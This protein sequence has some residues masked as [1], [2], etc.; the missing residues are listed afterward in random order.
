MKYL[1]S[2]V[3][4]KESVTYVGLT[5]IDLSESLLKSHDDLL[6]TLGK[7]LLFS[8]DDKMSKMLSE[9]KELYKYLDLDKLNSDSN[10]FDSLNSLGLKKSEIKNSLDFENFINKPCKFMFLYS[11]D[12]NE[13][14]GLENPDYVL[15]QTWNE[16]IQKWDELK[17][18]LVE[19]DINNFLNKL[20]SRTIQLTDNGKN[21]IYTTSNGN[22]WSLEDDNLADDTFKSNLRKEEL[23]KIIDEKQIEFQV[24]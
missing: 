11:R 4:F 16:T 12:K 20:T 7:E 13:N 8:A 1:K 23:Q 14:A 6:N 3:R 2:Y 21:Y 17:L 18:Y 24:K 5:N 9:L 15:F 10:F 19:Y 22:D